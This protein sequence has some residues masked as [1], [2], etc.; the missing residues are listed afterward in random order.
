MKPGSVILIAGAAL[1][2]AA[3]AADIYF[4]TDESGRTHLSDSVPAAYRKSALRIDSSR[5]DLTPEQQRDAAAARAS[6]ANKA[7]AP[8]PQPAPVA[9][10]RS[11]GRAGPPP[12]TRP[13]APADCDALQREY[14]ESLECFAPFVNANGS[15]K[16]EG[17]ATCKSVVNPTQKCG[18][19]KAY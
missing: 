11:A 12:A 8:V 1:S 17:F 16:P 15:V 10:P 5:F 7:S 14:I 3:Q 9:A 2:F 4:W 6:L 19:A 18:S 13:G